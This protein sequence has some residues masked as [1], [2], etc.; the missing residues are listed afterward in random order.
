MILQEIIGKYKIKEIIKRLLE[1]YPEQKKN[2][3]GYNKSLKELLYL[4]PKRSRVKINIDKFYDKDDKKYYYSVDGIDKNNESWAIE[5]TDW[6][7]WIGMEISEETLKENTEID[8][9]VH[10]L[11]EMT[12]VGFSNKNIKNEKNKLFNIMKSIKK[13]VTNG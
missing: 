8:I 11:W 7:E 9:L 13:E 5:F 10:C 2:I 6:K 12:F 4:S 1:I 3:A